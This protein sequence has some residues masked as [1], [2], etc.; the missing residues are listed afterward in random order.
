MSARARLA[1]IAGVMLIGSVAS[2]ASSA[3]VVAESLRRTGHASAATNGASQWVWGTHVQHRRRASMRHTALG[4]L[5]HHASASL[6]ASVYDSDLA[7]AWLHR[8]STRSIAVAALAAAVDYLVVP[9]RFG[10]GFEGQMSRPAIVATYL[11]FAG[12]LMLGSNTRRAATG[13][14]A[15]HRSRRVRAP[16]GR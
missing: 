14:N 16:R 13:I 12:G 7:R 4:Y 10:P 2:I 3:V 6:W 15:E 8:R 9:R 1:R 11:M 5:I